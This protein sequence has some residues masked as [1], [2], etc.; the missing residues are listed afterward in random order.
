MGRHDP[1]V[2]GKAQPPDLFSLERRAALRRSPSFSRL[3]VGSRARLRPTRIW[4][5]FAASHAGAHAPP[6][7][8]P[9]ACVQSVFA[10]LRSR[11]LTCAFNNRL[12]RSNNSFKPTPFR[13]VACVRSL[14]S[15]ASPH[16]SR[17]GLTQALERS[18]ETAL[19]GKEP[20]VL[21]KAQA[22]GRF[23]VLKAALRSGLPTTCS[24]RFR[25]GRVSL[26]QTRT[27]QGF[28]VHTQSR[29]R[30]HAPRTRLR[31][32]GTSLAWQPIWLGSWQ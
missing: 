2:L 1:G 6:C 24:R 13:C 27:E 4:Q 31:A 9:R 7:G 29:S 10:G 30:H 28:A 5:W 22:P 17:R 16:R 15:H 19:L 20:S 3:F 8:S 18:H 14:R 25:A 23:S 12:V 26:R 11:C 21:G 32:R